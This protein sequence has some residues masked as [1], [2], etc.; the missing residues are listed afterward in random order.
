MEANTA[1]TSGHPALAWTIGAGLLVV[2]IG[3]AAVLLRPQE[4]VAHSGV[5]E[6]LELDRG[7]LAL[8]EAAWTSGTV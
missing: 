5:V 4:A 6:P 3:F 1:W 8:P 2:A 7:E